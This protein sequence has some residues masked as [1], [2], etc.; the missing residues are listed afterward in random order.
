MVRAVCDVYRSH[1]PFVSRNLV[2]EIRR[3]PHAF[4][5]D[6][7]RPVARREDRTRVLD[8]S[9]SIIVASSGMLSGGPSAGYCRQLVKNANDAILLTG[10]QDEESPGRALLN[11]AQAE[12]PKEVRLGQ[13]TLPVNCL[14]GTYGLSAHADR[15]QM[16]SLIEA[17]SPRTVV[18]VH[19]DEGAK[20]SLAR[21][22]QCRDVLCAHDGLTIQR[23]YR[24]RSASERRPSARVPAADDLDIKRARNLLGPAGAAP[25]RAA[26]VAEA[27]FGQRVDRTTAEQLA[28]VL[29]SVGLVRRDDHRR[30]RLWV[31]SVLETSLFP[32]EAQLEE[33]MKQANPKGRLL[34]LCMRIRIE[35]PAA[36]VQQ[37]GAFYEAR[38]TLQYQGQSL[39]SGPAQAASKKTAEQLAAQ[40]LLNLISGDEKQDE[41]VRVTEE[42]AIRL[43]SINPKGRLLER[44]AKSKT[45]PPRFEQEASAEGYRMRAVLAMDDR[46]DIVTAW[47]VAPKLKTAEQAAANSLLQQLPEHGSEDMRPAA[48]MAAVQPAPERPSS[49]NA[50]MALNELTQAGLL[51]ATGYEQLG[52]TGP[53]HQPTFAVIAWATTPDGHTLRTDAA[54][55]SSKKSAQRAAA[56]H[57][58]NLLVEEGITRRRANDG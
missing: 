56:E 44:C 17:T 5:T 36:D 29:E 46:D 38:M 50:A 53:S 25:L 26:A 9:P 33:Q 41:A 15:M 6:S 52:Q 47:Y 12:G 40:A 57:L 39:D 58:L 45:L 37:R 51:Q 13:S 22:L 34:E 7:I 30:D 2:H 27:W 55:A 3:T 8:T 21:S 49:L 35:P 48:T 31:L 19:G 32:D 54:H 18:L 20:Q 1:E 14:F 16:V 28:R 43:Q 23:S 10:Y 42:E 11:L 24:P 4:Y